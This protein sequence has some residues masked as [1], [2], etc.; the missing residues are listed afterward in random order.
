MGKLANLQQALNTSSGKSH[1]VEP[2][3]QTAPTIVPS[4]RPSTTKA[5]ARAG[6]ENIAAWL[7]SDF[8]KSIRLVQAK[9]AGD[10]SL[11]DLMA[12]AFNDLFIKYNVPTVSE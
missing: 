10:P 5:A 12:E 9:R 11:Q 1:A 8:K 3:T 7:P 2:I 4:M 6:K